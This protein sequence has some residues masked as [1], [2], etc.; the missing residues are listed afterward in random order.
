MYMCPS[1]YP[2]ALGIHGPNFRDGCLCGVANIHRILNI[3]EVGTYLGNTC[4]ID[5]GHIRVPPEL[6]WYIHVVQPYEGFGNLVDAL[7]TVLT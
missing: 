7:V 2:W 3:W 4:T 6:V 5:N 1:K